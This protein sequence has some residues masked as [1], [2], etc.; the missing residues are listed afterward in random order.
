MVEGIS[1]TF[2]DNQSH[3]RQYSTFCASHRKAQE[4]TGN[5]L[6]SVSYCIEMFDSSSCGGPAA[7][8]IF[9]GTQPSSGL[10]TQTQLTSIKTHCGEFNS[11]C[12]RGPCSH[13]DLSL[14]YNTI[15]G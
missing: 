14:V 10:I 11:W 13:T 5:V 2:L 6:M 3:F 1:K 12:S 9:R 15:L 7:S 4:L 8:V